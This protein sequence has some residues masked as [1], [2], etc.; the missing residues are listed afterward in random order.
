[1]DVYFASKNVIFLG[2]FILF[3]LRAHTQRHTRLYIYTYVNEFSS[4]ERELYSA[5]RFWNVMVRHTSKKFPDCGAVDGNLLVGRQQDIDV[6][7]SYC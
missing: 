3:L 2:T 5:I 4:K 1:M 7:F 6:P